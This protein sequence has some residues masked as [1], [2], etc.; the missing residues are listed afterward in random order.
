MSN[1]KLPLVVELDEVPDMERAFR[2][3]SGLPHC[4]F[5]DSVV[6]DAPLG[7]YSFMTADPFDTIRAPADGSDALAELQ[8]RMASLPVVPLAD[9]PPFQGGAAGLFGWVLSM[10]FVPAAIT[11]GLLSG[12]ESLISPL[13]DTLTDAQFFMVRKYVVLI[14]LNLALLVIGMFVD[15]GP[16]III[17]APIVAPIGR[18]LGMD[19][20]HFGVMVVTNLVIGLVTPP[21]GTTL[22]VASGVGKVKLGEMIP[23]VMKFL[24]VMVTA[25]LLIVV[26]PG[27]TTWLP[28]FIK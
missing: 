1:V 16:A 27:I 17:L 6:Q 19:D 2:H 22:F 8:R 25:Q 11:E 15:A 26:I 5:L 7:R 4:L 14:A 9:L 13:R 20:Y 3:L 18:E 21:V 28:S 24:G 12:S 10:G 23:H